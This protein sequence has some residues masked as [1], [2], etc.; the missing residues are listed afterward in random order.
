MTNNIYLILLAVHILIIIV[1]YNLL[2]NPKP[3]PPEEIRKELKS[4]GGSLASFKF[5]R[6]SHYLLPR[7]AKSQLNWKNG[8]YFW[9]KS[10]IKLGIIGISLT[11]LTIILGEYFKI[12]DPLIGLFIIFIPVSLGMIYLCIRMEKDILKD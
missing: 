7:L 10:A 6:F 2:K 1:N 3:Y 4:G 12:F 8:N 9:Y 11:I 5:V